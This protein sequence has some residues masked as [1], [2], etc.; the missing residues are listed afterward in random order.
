MRIK[1][2]LVF[3]NYSRYYDL[4]YKDKDYD[5]EAD[6]I[7]ELIQR[8]IP[9]AKTI[10]DLGCGTGVHDVLLA[11]K[12]YYIDA[13]DFSEEMLSEARKK[14]GI[15]P[16]FVSSINFHF[17][18]IRNIRLNKTF[19]VVLSLFHV[20]SYQ[21]TNK[22]FMDAV[23]TAKNHLNKK[24][25]FIFDCWY[26]P[27]VLTEKPTVRVKKIQDDNIEITRIAEPIHYPDRNLVD[28]CYTVFIKD[29]R[30]NLIQEIHETHTMRY[31][32]IPE[33]KLMLE[34]AGFKII[35][36]EEWVTKKKL[37]LDTWGAL[38]VSQKQ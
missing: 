21:T 37:G 28:V 15:L 9:R 16:E 1:M 31:L 36:S 27:T 20:M 30:N 22:D 8:F 18:D 26:G 2:S 17:G 6:Y 5:I 14:A 10:L 35:I 32:F 3:N 4:L 7:S 24:G 29:K 38:F 19:D 13:V 34:N 12:G 33:L 25:I 11:Q 23:T